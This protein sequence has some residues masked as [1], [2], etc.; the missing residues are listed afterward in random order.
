MRRR[1]RYRTLPEV[2][3]TC[4]GVR[5]TW[6]DRT[7]TV[8]VR[9]HGVTNL[10]CPSRYRD[11]GL[12]DHTRPRCLHRSRSCR[13]PTALCVRTLGEI[14]NVTWTRVGSDLRWSGCFHPSSPVTTPNPV[15]NPP[16]RDY[17]RPMDLDGPA[18][19]HEKGNRPGRGRGDETST[20]NRRGHESTNP[21]SKEDLTRPLV[22]RSGFRSGF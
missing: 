15:E 12:P 4:R 2:V 9:P 16:G 22:N 11:P 13:D 17:D 7:S 20:L 8:P 19:T 18:W 6:N 10:I 5:P 21:G 3:P 14:G 1:R